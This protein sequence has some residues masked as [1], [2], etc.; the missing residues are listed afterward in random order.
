MGQ[1]PFLLPDTVSQKLVHYKFEKTGENDFKN[2]KYIQMIFLK[3]KSNIFFW[4]FQRK[5]PYFFQMLNTPTCVIWHKLKLHISEICQCHFHIQKVSITWSFLCLVSDKGS[6]R[7]CRCLLTF[8]LYFRNRWQRGSRTTLSKLPRNRN[9]NPCPT[10]RSGHD[11][12]DSVH[13]WRMPR[14]R[15]MNLWN[16]IDFFLLP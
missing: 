11:A 2:F 1:M 6:W 8:F 7:P 10:V 13:V 9:A 3:K 4:K 14:T 15:W 16:K 5:S 12:T